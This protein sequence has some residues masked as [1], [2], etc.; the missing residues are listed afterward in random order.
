MV[1]P[2]TAH[3]EPRAPMSTRPAVAAL[4]AA[5]TANGAGHAFL[6]ITL[7][8]LGRARGFGDVETGLLLG[9]SALLMVVAGPVWGHVADRI[10]RRP[11]LVAGLAAAALFPAL[12]A[13][14]LDALDGG[15]LDAGRAYGLL[16]AARL[17]QAAISAGIMPAAQGFLAD[18][19]ARDRRAGGMGMMG[20]AFGLGSIL[21]GMTAWRLGGASPAVALLVLS[22]AIAAGTLLVALVLRATARPVSTATTATPRPPLGRLLPFLAITFAGLAAYAQLQQVTALRLQDQF[23]LAP[24][25]SIERG[26]ALLALTTLAMVATQGLVIGRLGWAPARLVR[27]GAVLALLAMAMAA[28]AP[29]ILW[30]QIAM[31]LLGAGFGLLLPGNLAGLSLATPAGAQARAAGINGM[32]QGLA[33][34]A[35]PMLGAMLHQLSPTAPWWAGA[36]LLAVI[37]GIACRRRSEAFAG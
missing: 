18:V 6:L 12:L 9:L 4:L 26:G 23:G 17:V 29:A 34:A 16:L 15:R 11:V 22:A 21:G 24:A 7:P 35:G 14:T 2:P 30:L 8:P 13:W 19:T 1:P 37:A 32:A 3:P 33:M 27:R 28:A 10:G 31:V 20:A 25:A 36:V 5:L